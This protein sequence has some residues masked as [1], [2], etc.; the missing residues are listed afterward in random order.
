MPY[1]AG[2][3]VL[4]G[5]YEALLTRSRGMLLRDIDRA[6]LRAAA[7]LRAVT[8]VRTPDALQLTAALSEGC[9]AFVTNDQ[10]LHSLP[11]LPVLQLSDYV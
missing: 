3:M 6:Q 8:G 10:R 5:R 4:A 2:N 7:Q 9:T 11:G 1:R